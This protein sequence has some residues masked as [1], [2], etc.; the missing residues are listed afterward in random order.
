M[1]FRSVTL[2]S[3]ADA[4]LDAASISTRFTGPALEQRLAN[5]KVR[6]VDAE[7]AATTALPDAPLTLTLPQQ[8]DS[9]PRE[10]MT[11]LQSPD[12][13]SVPTMALVL[14][15]AS[16]R[17]N[18][19]VEYAIQLG[20]SARVPGVAPATVGA[21]E[22]TPDNKF[23][24]MAPEAV[25]PAYADILLNGEASPAYSLFEA[26]GDTARTQL[27]VESKQAKKDALEDTATIDFSNE[28]GSGDVVALATNDS[29]SIVAVS[30]NEIHTV[31]SVNGKATIEP[32]SGPSRA[33]SGIDKTN[34]GIESTY[35]EQYLFHVPAAGSTD[36]IVLLGFSQGLIESVELP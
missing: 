3:A 19:L 2:T 6:T 21:V 17:E 34:K 31:T 10:V 9:W 29:G 18:Y 15:Q 16:P 14:T 33:L 27:G 11:V 22:V 30:V 4:G 8:T 25:G 13:A 5:Y 36:K 24:S 12:E 20:A 23:M 7:S 26:E 32:T 35:G 1:L 28:V